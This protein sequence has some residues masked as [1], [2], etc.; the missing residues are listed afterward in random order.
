MNSDAN[1][2]S[3]EPAAIDAG[4]DSIFA[5]EKWEQRSPAPRPFEPW[6]RPRKQ[7]VREEV[8]GAEIDWLIR[9]KHVGD[10]SVRYLGLPGADLL[11]LRYIY[12]EF[13]KT[14][15]HRLKFLGFDSAALPNSLHGDALNISLQEVRSLPHVDKGSE[16]L[17]DNFRL[18]AD[19]QS[20]A[21]AAAERMGPFDVIN[22][23][24]CTQLAAEEPAMDVSI[25]NAIYNICALQNRRPGP[26][27]LL[28]TSRIDRESVASTAL[29]KLVQALKHN[30]ENCPGFLQSFSDI[31]GLN[32]ISMAGIADL[33]DGDFLNATMIGL[34]KWLLGLACDINNRFSVSE[35]I[36]YRVYGGA[37]HL[38]MVSV[39]YRFVPVVVMP[40]DRIGLATAAPERPSECEQAAEIPSAIVGI[41]DVDAKLRDTPKLYETFRDKTAELLQQARY[42]P[43]AYKKWA[44]SK[45]GPIAQSSGKLCAA[46]SSSPDRIAPLGGRVAGWPWV[47]VH[48]CPVDR[49][50]RTL[51]AWILH[52]PPSAV[53]LVGDIRFCRSA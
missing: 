22:I 35:I 40:A 19:K 23:D 13:C 49:A 36:G 30:L 44:D 43:L 37:P 47:M 12:Q 11:D 50:Y 3:D 46:E 45:R 24:L 51:L 4:M 14:G 42:D 52:L 17:G 25:Y 5:R 34:A 9:Q 16:V 53:S 20:I 21:W 48:P 38:D 27:S 29:E 6:H 1:D 31:M 18:L 10:E 41:V 26:W 33:T 2:F 28:L 8:W 39:V 32:D 7:L 15:E